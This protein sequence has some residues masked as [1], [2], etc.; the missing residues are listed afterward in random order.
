MLQWARTAVRRRHQRLVKVAQEA[1]S[2]A[3]M[4]LADARRAASEAEE[5]GSGV[6]LVGVP[7][8]R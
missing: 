1:E 5:A 6:V 7:L 2:M 3:Q 4:G 8:L